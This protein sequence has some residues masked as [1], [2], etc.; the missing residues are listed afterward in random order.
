MKHAETYELSQDS[1]H[2]EHFFG[3]YHGG[4]SHNV[5]CAAKRTLRRIKCADHFPQRVEVSLD[6]EESE[7]VLTVHVDDE[8]FR[9]PSNVVIF[10]EGPFLPYLWVPVDAKVRVLGGN[11][12]ELT[13]AAR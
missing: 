7:T 1:E 13:K 11:T 12:V 10:P 4:A 3:Y 9:V 5:A 2:A 6:V 8:I